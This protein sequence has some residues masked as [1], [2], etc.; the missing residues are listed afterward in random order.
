[1]SQNGLYRLILFIAAAALLF[2]GIYFYMERCIMIDS[3]FYIFYMI[4]DNIFQIQHNRIFA[5]FTQFLPM[6]LFNLNASLKPILLSY[7]LNT[8][9]V[10]IFLATCTVLIWRDYK[11]ALALIVSPFLFNSREFFW[12]V[13]EAQFLP[14]LWIFVA[15][16]LLNTNSRKHLIVKIP[17]LIILLFFAITVHPLSVFPLFFLILFLLIKGYD[18]RFLAIFLVATLFVFLLKS[19]FLPASPYDQGAMTRLSNF[20]YVAPNYCYLAPNKML[21]ANLSAQFYFIPIMLFLCLISFEGIK[22]FFSGFI[23]CLGIVAFFIFINVCFYDL[24]EYSVIY[25]ENVYQ[26]IISALLIPVFFSA[27]S[28]KT[29]RLLIVVSSTI[30]FFGIIRLWDTSKHFTKRLEWERSIIAKYGTEKVAL[31]TEIVP[32]DLLLHNWCVPY[33]IALLSSAENEYCSSVFVYANEEE[34]KNIDDRGR[35][36]VTVF[37]PIRYDWIPADIFRYTDSVNCYRIVSPD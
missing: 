3:S 13:S 2:F 23:Y 29:D 6:L 26:P 37:K 4:K 11:A 30:L 17:I 34:Q 20:K 28:M 15:A 27:K 24:Q 18:K 21:F 12:M 19:F 10:W 35:H 1:M 16:F 33:E 14:A 5:V 32:M 25:L 7:S 36:I 31:S 9:M 22:K 8:A